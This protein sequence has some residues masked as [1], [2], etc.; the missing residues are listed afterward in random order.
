MSYVNE[1]LKARKLADDYQIPS[2]G[3]SFIEPPL[4]VVDLKRCIMT[5]K[6]A[7]QGMEAPA[8]PDPRRTCVPVCMVISKALEQAGYQ[9]EITYGNVIKKGKPLLSNVSAEGML[10]KYHSPESKRQPN[11]YCWLTLNDGSIVDFT[12]RGRASGQVDTEK[13]AQSFLFLPAG[14]EDKDYRFEPM[15]IGNR[16]FLETIIRGDR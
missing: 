11:F 13:M 9:H 8:S 12:I 15:L 16:E 4:K 5:A 14:E 3:L 10:E 1:L 2:N 7:V 6:K